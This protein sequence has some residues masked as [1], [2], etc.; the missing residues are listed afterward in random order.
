MIDSVTANQSSYLVQLR[1]CAHDSPG[2]GYLKLP[3]V[4]AAGHDAH[5][6][7]T[8]CPFPVRLPPLIKSRFQAKLAILLIPFYFLWCRKSTV[9]WN[10]LKES[11][12]QWLMWEF[13]F[14]ITV[15]FSLTF[16]LI[17][18]FFFALVYSNTFA[19]F[20]LECKTS[21]FQVCFAHF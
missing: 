4:H 5:F 2:I 12:F 20:L 10:R 18:F 13:A 15:T 1:F 8:R 16:S 11:P 17:F 14:T 6:F 3:L 9:S 19:I 7:D 21:H